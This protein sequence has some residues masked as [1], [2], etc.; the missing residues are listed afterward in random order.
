MT[1]AYK[2]CKSMPYKIVYFIVFSFHQT[3]ENEELRLEDRT[4][5]NKIM[6]NQTCMKFCI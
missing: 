6:L 4:K 5:T 3:V 1:V 2:I